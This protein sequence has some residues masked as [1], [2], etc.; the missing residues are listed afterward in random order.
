MKAEPASIPSSLRNRL[1]GRISK[2]Q[3]LES[4]YNGR[5]LL[6]FCAVYREIPFE[7]D[8]SRY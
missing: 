5:F 1:P 2:G 4:P 7:E 8:P 6:T 3:T